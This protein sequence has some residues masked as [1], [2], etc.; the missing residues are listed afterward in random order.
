M[1]ENKKKVSLARLDKAKD[2]NLVDKD[3]MPL[4]D[5]INNHPN[6]YTTSSCLGRIV[7]AESPENDRKQEYVWLGKWH[8]KVNLDEVTNAIQKHE[9]NILWF[10]MDPLILHICC[11][12]IDNADLLLKC[13]KTAGLKRSGI[14]QVNPRIMVE[15]LG[16]DN[17]CAPILSKIDDMQLETLV[18]VSNTRIDKNL[19][20][21]ELFTKEINAL[22]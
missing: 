12:T 20:K 2:E 1:F 17:V 4:V 3:I 16:V 22:F 5:L 9:K 8:R 18:T 21:L 14:V 7:V 10:R 6:Y 13:A 19:K 15:I 11:D